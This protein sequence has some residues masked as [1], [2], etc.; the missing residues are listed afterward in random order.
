MYCIALKHLYSAPHSL[1]PYRSAF[2]S[3]SSK[4]TNRF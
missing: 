1:K 2:G 3:T 4:K